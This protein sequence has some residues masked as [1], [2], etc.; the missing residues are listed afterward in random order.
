MILWVNWAPLCSPSC[1]MC[2][3]WNHSC[4][5]IILG[6]KLGPE[7]PKWLSS[8]LPESFSTCLSSNSSF[9]EIEVW[10]LRGSI[11]KDLPHMQ[12]YKKLLLASC[13]LISYWS[14]QVT[15]IMRRGPHKSLRDKRFIDCYR[16]AVY[17]SLRATHLKR[18][19]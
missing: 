14:K 9:L 18:T 17:H 10:I 16:S 15:Q 6:A 12:V 13:L 7:H 11:Q 2:Y 4:C 5:S 1:S 3:N 19:L 8:Y